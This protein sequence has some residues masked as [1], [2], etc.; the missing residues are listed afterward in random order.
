MLLSAT[1]TRGLLIVEKL[2]SWRGSLDLRCPAQPR[3]ATLA[4]ALIDLVPTSMVHHFNPVSVRVSKKPAELA[5]IHLGF[6]IKRQRPR[7]TD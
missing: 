4:L 7:E 1:N 6:P 5:V 2:T 3:H